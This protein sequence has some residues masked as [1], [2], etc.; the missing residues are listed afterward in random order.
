MN[1][2]E[3]A[4][5]PFLD[6][7]REYAGEGFDLTLEDLKDDVYR[8]V[9]DRALERVKEAIKEREVHQDAEDLYDYRTE[10]LSFP[11]AVALVS[12]IGDNRL[13]EIFSLAEAK[14]ARG[15]LNNESSAYLVNFANELG[16]SAKEEN[17]NFGIQVL[18]Y[19]RFVTA[20]KGA[21][22]WKLANRVL[23]KGYVIVNANEFRRLIQE[24]IREKICNKTLKEVSPNDFPSVSLK[25]IQEIKELWATVVRDQ[26]KTPSRNLRGIPPCIGGLKAKIERGENLSHFERFALAT[27]LLNTD[28][29]V[30]EV[31][32]VFSSSPD[33]NLRV[34]RYQIEH[35][36]GLRGVKKKYTTPNCD[37]MRKS[38]LCNPDV[39]CE[40]INNPLS[41]RR[42]GKED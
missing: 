12:C 34:A 24:A 36:A 37:A 9:W 30:E 11:L 8:R 28:R 31:L 16:V 3:L 33:F 41:Y 39:G 10:I 21:S 27:Y 7:A 20:F 32:E 2:L 19:L 14:R 18:S 17:G 25:F 38:N 15:H 13:R 35:L 4:K 26:I 22:N 23:S 40:G 5:Y 1:V 6:R 42:A 29:S